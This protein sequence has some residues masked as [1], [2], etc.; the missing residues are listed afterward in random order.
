[1]FSYDTVT[2]KPELSATMPSF[3]V[4]DRPDFETRIQ[5][6]QYEGLTARQGMRFSGS[7]YGGHETFLTWPEAFHTSFNILPPGT[8]KSAHPAWYDTTGNQLCYTARGNDS[9]LEA[10]LN[11]SVAAIVA[12]MN[13]QPRARIAHFGI[14]DVTASCGCPACT[15]EREKYGTDSA[16]VIKFMNKL[17]EKL[18]AA[19]PHPITLSYFAYFHTVK[20]PV[21][22][23][24]GEYV[25]IDDGVRIRPGVG[26]MVAPLGANYTRSFYESENSDTA[27]QIKGWN[28][29]TDTMLMWLYQTNFHNYMYPYNSFS[30]T[31]DTYKFAKENGGIYMFNQGTYNMPNATAFNWFKL[32][33][34]SKAQWDV[35]ANYSKVADDFFAG[36]FREAG[37]PMRRYFDEL[38]VYM[39]YIQEEN[40]ELGGKVQCDISQAKYW[41]KGAL[42]HW[43]ALID[44]A[45]AAIAKYKDANPALYDVLYRHIL[46]E[47]LFPRFALLV[48][49]D[50]YYQSAALT[51]LRRAFQQDCNELGISRVNEGA[52]MDTVY[53]QWGI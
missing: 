8:H 12:K 10:M 5:A 49:H 36:Y 24:N 46:T 25:P 53:Q 32:Y 45:Y 40:K 23:E 50:A 4:V 18:Q 27:E 29:L 16:V 21:K 39:R 37:E 31:S 13:E 34:D 20:P 51:V 26:V 19:A 28:A 41:Q 43:M 22:E 48:H 1:M 9:E 52:T 17:D 38:Q 47:S 33:F 14:Q 6:N 3:N 30:S 7:Q 35:N 44:E 42:D 11:Q 15:S 2:Y